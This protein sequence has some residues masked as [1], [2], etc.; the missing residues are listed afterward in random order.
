MFSVSY[1]LG[2]RTVTRRVKLSATDTRVSSLRVPEWMDRDL[3]AEDV[4]D[5]AWL[6]SKQ[7]PKIRKP[8]REIRAIDL[9]CGCGG[10][11]LGVREAARAL[12]C[13]FR[14]VFAS[15][16]DYNALDLYTRNF[17]PDIADNNP[18]EHIING[19]LGSPATASEKTFLDR[20]NHI[21]IVV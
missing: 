9:F 14:C 17:H 10:L 15:D 8:I 18:I 12:G 6:A 11:T 3:S 16:I 5:L 21:D 19:D 1:K 7:E 13:S 2:K 20:V 4:Y